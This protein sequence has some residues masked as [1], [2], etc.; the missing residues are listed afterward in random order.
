MNE[1]EQL[2]NENNRFRD[3]LESI[4]ALSDWQQAKRLMVLR[5]KEALAEC[6]PSYHAEDEA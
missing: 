3:A 5:A 4:I 1:L 6:D 2:R